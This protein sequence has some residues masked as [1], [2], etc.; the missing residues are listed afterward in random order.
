MSSFWSLL[1]PGDV[2]AREKVEAIQASAAAQ[3]ED[4][5]PVVKP[6]PEPRIDSAHR[7]RR[8]DAL[9][10]GGIAFTCLSLFITRRALV[11]KRIQTNPN[12]FT[13]SNTP[14]PKVDG[15]IEAAEALGLAT[16]NVFSIA[17][18]AAGG[19]MTYFDIADIEDM[20][21]TVRKG[22]GFDVYGGESEADKEIEGWI[23]DV[24]SRKDGEGDL[25]GNI[26]EKL[27]ELAEI[28]KKRG[29]EDRRKG[30]R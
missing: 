23:A 11:R 10:Y 9:L 25:R 29:L 16:L 2:R 13:P 18:V 19:L 4:S 27:H 6:T 22:V 24:L 3:H 26:A 28:E 21:D 20:R 15:A 14:P 8:K 5:K 7:Q 1:R 17:M 12:T 30:E